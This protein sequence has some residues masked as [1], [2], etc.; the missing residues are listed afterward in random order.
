MFRFS[1]IA[2]LSDIRKDV[3]RHPPELEGEGYPLLG[4]CQSHKMNDRVTDN[5]VVAKQANLLKT[6]LTYSTSELPANLTVY[7]VRAQVVLSP[8]VYRFQ[9]SSP[10][11]LR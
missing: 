4:S 8:F 11:Y 6:Y 2:M 1:M 3:I 10:G 5:S 9:D 7:P